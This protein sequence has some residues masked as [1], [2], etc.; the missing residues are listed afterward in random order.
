MGKQFYSTH[1]IARI[2]NVSLTTV[3]GWIDRKLLPGFKTPGGHRRVK[4]EDLAAF[5]R[6][7]RMPAPPSLMPAK[8]RVLVVD[9]D[10]A[11]RESV[12]DALRASGNYEV[13]TCGSGFEAGRRVIE[14]RPDA[15]LL[16]FIMPDLDGFQVCKL[17]KEREE[18][19]N[20]AIIAMTVIEDEPRVSR[21]RR[22][23]VDAHVA[24]PFDLDVL[25][26]TIDKVL[27]KKGRAGSRRGRLAD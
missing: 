4:S 3:A 26:A 24:K 11:I 1:E 18:T 16:D 27:A 13:K 23:G 5:L 20:V 25:A 15:I 22:M 19:R 12:S 2:C 14:W 10:P 8:T 7:F 21:M 17:L 6:K 9:D